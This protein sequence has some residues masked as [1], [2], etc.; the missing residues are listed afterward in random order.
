MW[1]ANRGHAGLV[2][3]LLERGADPNRQDRVK[4]NEGKT[5]L[6]YAEPRSRKVLDLLLQHGADPGTRDREGLNAVEEALDQAAAFRDA[7]DRAE[8]AALERKAAAIQ[9]AISRPSR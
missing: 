4:Y 8:A 6:M 9:A 3:L 1:A 7:D 5:A 2:K